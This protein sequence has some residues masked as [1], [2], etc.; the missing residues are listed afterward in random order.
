MTF[1]LSGAA[2]AGIAVGGATLISGLSQA[3]AAENAAG[4]QAGAA[5]SGIEEQR[6]Q[7]VAV[8]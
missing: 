4:I 3:N 7:F 8:Q 1:G 6:R 2:L 5:Q